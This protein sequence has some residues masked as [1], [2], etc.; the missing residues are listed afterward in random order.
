MVGSHI[1]HFK[2]IDA[3]LEP[4]ESV[5]HIVDQIEYFQIRCFVAGMVAG[6]LFM[7]KV[8]VRQEFFYQFISALWPSF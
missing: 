3:V 1:G 2:M 7:G 4:W 8:P 5:T 6:I